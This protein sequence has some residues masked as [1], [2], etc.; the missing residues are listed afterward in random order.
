M[1]FN[2]G[3]ESGAAAWLTLMG[4]GAV[5]AGGDP[6]RGKLPWYNREDGKVGKVLHGR[7][8]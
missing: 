4:E 6:A 3:V 7:R 8:R 2:Q 1:L 5:P